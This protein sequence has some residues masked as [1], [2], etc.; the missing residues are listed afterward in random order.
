[1]AIRRNAPRIHVLRPLELIAFLILMYGAIGVASLVWPERPED[2]SDVWT[3]SVAILVICGVVAG[4]WITEQWR[5]RK[6]H[7]VSLPPG[8]AWSLSATVL[9]LAS[10]LSPAVVY[11]NI[12]SYQIRD[13]VSLQ[14]VLDANAKLG[15]PG[16]PLSRPLRFPVTFSHRTHT[17]L[18]V[19]PDAPDRALRIEHHLGSAFGVCRH[20]VRTRHSAVNQEE[21]KQLSWPFGGP[22]DDE[23]DEIFA[24]C[25]RA[26]EDGSSVEQRRMHL[27]SVARHEASLRRFIG[28]AQFALLAY[29]LGDPYIDRRVP[30]EHRRY[31]ARSF[32]LEDPSWL[33]ALAVVTVTA[34]MF[35]WLATYVR[36]RYPAILLVYA[37]LAILVPVALDFRLLTVEIVWATRLALGALTLL[38]LTGV[39][40]SAIRGR[41]LG[42]TEFSLTWCLF[43]PCLWTA[44]EW[45][46]SRDHLDNPFLV[47]SPEQG[48]PATV[49]TCQYGWGCQ[50]VMGALVLIV[51]LGW[52]LSPLVDRLRSMARG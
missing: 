36:L 14:T 8:L 40:V 15:Q 42:I 3:S 21:L 2:I 26:T 10:I 49:L 50:V 20:A 45:G 30:Q 6:R 1:M 27:R 48:G 52:A 25:L 46:W 11:S 39:A 17:A 5:R 38:G 9:I 33:L 4:A 22:S 47:R 18:L 35:T 19:E 41:Y 34:G 16:I 32:P 12:R 24:D 51:L 37:T 31:I 13:A 23:W 28:S 44:A 7:P 43:V 29:R